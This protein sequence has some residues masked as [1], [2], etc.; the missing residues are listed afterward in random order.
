MSLT[1]PEA[2]ALVSGYDRVFLQE[3]ER[4]SARARQG[5]QDA[6]SRTEAG[7]AAA[8]ILCAVAACE[9]YLSEYLAR[10]ELARDTL[11]A[12]L[13]SI[14]D[15]SDSLRQWNQLLKHQAPDF[16]VG[17]RREYLALGCLLQVRDLVAHRHA[18][19]LP[20][21]SFPTSLSDCVRQRVVPVYKAPGADWT[22][23]VFV[24][25]VAE[26]AARTAGAWL[27]IAD[28]TLPAP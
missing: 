15:D 1:G 11:D 26:W 2:A 10:L 17:S 3:A 23:V 19:T 5:R 6:D 9:A 22:S 8:A 27:D 24:V 7:G 16:A 20:L 14:R 25:E 18:R 28:A 12:D 4:S 13:A 21:G